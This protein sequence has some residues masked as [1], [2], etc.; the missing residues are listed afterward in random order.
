MKPTLYILCGLPY[1][2][3]STLTRELVKRHKFEVC[4]VD[5]QIDKY[6]MD[7]DEM[8]QDDWN[9]VYSEAYENLKKDLRAGKSVIFDM[10]HLKRSERNTA[11]A[12]AKDC[13]VNH[14]LVYIN[15]PKEEIEKRWEENETTK[16]RGQLSRKGLDTAY[17]F[18]QEPQVDEDP[19][20]YNNKMDLN[21]WIK[22]YI[23]SDEN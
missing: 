15:T 10:G 3:K 6:K 5:N 1:C 13:G 23:T 2:G 12:I 9:L 16:A 4:S 7:T 22:K 17:G 11:R 14:K 8:T 18:W 20:L 19:I 21:S